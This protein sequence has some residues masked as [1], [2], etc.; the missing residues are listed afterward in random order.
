MKLH[1]LGILWMIFGI[2][3]PTQ[4]SQTKNNLAAQSREQQNPQNLKNYNISTSFALPS[5]LLYWPILAQL[6]QT[7]KPSR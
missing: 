2:A 4:L 1:H 6:S 5:E 7:E 3:I